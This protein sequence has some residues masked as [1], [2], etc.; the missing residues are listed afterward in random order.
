MFTVMVKKKPGGQG[1]THPSVP[2]GPCSDP[3]I[4]E[5][6]DNGHLHLSYAGDQHPPP[7]PSSSLIPA[8]SS[9][10]TGDRHMRTHAAPERVPGRV[11]ANGAEALA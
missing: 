5:D 4:A 7:E 3:H 11:A 10:G 1:E 8:A 2:Q 6:P 9:R